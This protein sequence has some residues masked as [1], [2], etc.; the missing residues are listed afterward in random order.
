MVWNHFFKLNKKTFKKNKYEFNHMIRTD[1]ISICVLFVLLENGK[2]MSKS[3]GKKL[4]GFLDS[5][6]IENVKNISEINK[7]FV[8]A[9]PGKSDIFYCGSKNEDDELE[10]FR[11]T[12]NQRRLELGT[13]KYRNII[14]KVN[15]ETKINDKT[16]KEIESTLSL[17]NSKTVPNSN[18]R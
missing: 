12:Q 9:D 16:I 6:Y 5:N 8:L 17:V 14:H 15:T 2:P 10:T 3:K 1:G 4:K 18:L 13:T 11:Y 7:K